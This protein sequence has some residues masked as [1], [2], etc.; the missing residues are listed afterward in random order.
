MSKKKKM[1]KMP[2]TC[3]TCKGLRWN[4]G[5][6]CDKLS[7][8]EEIPDEG[9]ERALCKEYVPSPDAYARFVEHLEEQDHACRRCAFFVPKGYEYLP[10]QFSPRCARTGYAGHIAPDTTCPSFVSKGGLF[11]KEGER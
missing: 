6:F 1:P 8:S 5:L 11:G 7:S 9:A 4:G 10:G 2:K 3:Y